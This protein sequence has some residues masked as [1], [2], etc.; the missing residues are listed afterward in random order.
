MTKTHRR[1]SSR[2]SY[3]PENYSTLF[4][5][6]FEP[7]F[8]TQTFHFGDFKCAALLHEDVKKSLPQVFNRP[9]Y[10]R[11]LAF[12]TRHAGTKGLGMFSRCGI[13]AGSI[14]LAEHPLVAMPRSSSTNTSMIS[15][16]LSEVHPKEKTEFMNLFNSQPLEEPMKAIIQTNAF[17]I[18][19][20]VEDPELAAYHAVFL[21]V[22]R[23]NHSC[24]PNAHWK[25]DPA[26]FS[27]TLEA[28]RAIGPNEEITIQYIDSCVEREQRLVK[29]RTWYNFDCLCPTCTLPRESIIQSDFARE[30]LFQLSKHMPTFET[31]CASESLSDDYM[32]RMHQRALELREAE[33]LQLFES[34]KHIDAIAMCYGALGD[35][36]MFRCWTERARELR[37]TSYSGECVVLDRWM[38]DPQTFPV[39]GWRNRRRRDIV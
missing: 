37:A 10:H 18:D 28:V 23:C 21:K 25:W 16:L 22:S 3:P 31:W 9:S 4:N 8:I 2:Y 12:G 32:I 29:L 15:L 17:L 34:R 35:V 33:G 1:R 11:Q 20:P 24:S 19:L 26:S 39:W 6:A 36:P 5:R 27:L 7:R 30:E 14:I 38:M 13:P